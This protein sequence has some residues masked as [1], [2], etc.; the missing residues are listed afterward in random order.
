MCDITPGVLPTRAAYLSLG[1]RSFYWGL[2]IPSV[3]NSSEDEA[4]TTWSKALTIYH[5]VKPSSVAQGPQVNKDSVIR[6]DITRD[7]FL[8]AEGKGQASL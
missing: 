3:S 7:H 6:Q 5:I 4:D 2:V 8:G 1:V